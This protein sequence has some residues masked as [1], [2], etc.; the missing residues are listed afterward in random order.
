MIG[1]VTSLMAFFGRFERLQARLFELPFD[2]S[3]PRRLASS[4]TRRSLAH[5]AGGRLSMF[6]EKPSSRINDQRRDH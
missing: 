4:T 1:P 3:R 2:R 6:I 5:H